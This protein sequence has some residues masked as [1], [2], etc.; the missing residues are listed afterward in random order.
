MAYIV[1][2]FGQC[3]NQ[4]G[5]ELF[6]LAFNDSV[7]SDVSYWNNSCAM[8]C[9][10]DHNNAGL[11]NARAV[12]VDTERKVITNSIQSQKRNSLWSYASGNTV[13]G[14]E[15]GA[16]NNFALGYCEKGPQLKDEVL[17]V[18]RRESEKCDRVGGVIGIAGGAGGTGSG[19]GTHVLECVQDVSPHKNFVSVLVT[20]YSTGEV[21]TQNNNLLFTISKQ[22]DFCDAIVLFENDVIA[23]SSKNSFQGSSL[24]FTGSNK[25]I[26]ESILSFL[27][28]I[29]N[30][31]VDL[32]NL[33]SQLCPQPSFK[34]LTISNSP[35]QNETRSKFEPQV[36][37]NTVE[38]EILRS[39][40]SR[41][42]VTNESC[43]GT[44]AN[45][46]INRGENVP[47]KTISKIM[48]AFS[49]P[50]W[51]PVSQRCLVYHQPRPLL[52][53]EKRVAVV[54]NS[55]NITSLLDSSISKA[56]KLF[57][58]DMYVHLYYKFGFT[59]DDFMNMFVSSEKILKA[60][61][62]L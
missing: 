27:Q 28:P 9:W 42:S 58:N 5:K 34:L 51:M 41:V 23:N 35:F 22:N 54:S 45:V 38:R 3:G 6:S 36:H 61:K 43:V 21:V 19:V 40:R 2:Q 12:V 31:S 17:E 55:A 24:G 50:L 16:G 46:I 7:Q 53:L 20:P 18:F 4:L 49:Y 59:K 33:L 62:S 48:S 11:L 32:Y 8:D 60:Y 1:L 39:L 52:G 14:S 37:W 29:K 56:W 30:G 15:G 10:F 47:S 44:V 26:S 25:V 57:T 13:F